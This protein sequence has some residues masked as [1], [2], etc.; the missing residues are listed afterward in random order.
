MFL[1]KQKIVEPS[2]N[3]AL[4]SSCISF[5]GKRSERALF[6]MKFHPVTVKIYAIQS[7]KEKGLGHLHKDE[8][9]SVRGTQL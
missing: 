2:N 4:Q 6:P 1:D 5:N 9:C 7:C 8:N 3:Y